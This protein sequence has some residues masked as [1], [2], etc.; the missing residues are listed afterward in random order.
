[1][2]QLLLPPPHRYAEAVEEGAG[3]GAGTGGVAVRLWRPATAEQA[4][5]APVGGRDRVAE[6]LAT[7]LFT[8][9][10]KVFG[11]KMDRDAV[12]TLLRESI[13]GH[14][15]LPLTRAAQILGV[16]AFRAG[17]AVQ[18]LAQVLNTD[19]VVVLSVHGT[20]VELESAALFEQFGVAP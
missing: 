20:D 8:Q 6:L 11:R 3:Q 9:Q 1:M 10:Y 13:D 19:G 5:A 4:S 15:V 12:A 17:P 16:K 7:D 18:V 2:R 14:G